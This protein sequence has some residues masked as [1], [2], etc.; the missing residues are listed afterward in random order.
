MAGNLGT[1]YVGIKTDINQLKTGL[2]GAKRHVESFS[3][4]ARNRFNAVTSAVTGLYGKIA[5]LAG[6]YGLAKL[7]TSFLDAARTSENYEVRLKVLL[8]SVEEGNRLFEEMSKY[9]G[10]VPF[11]FE[12]IMG[13]ATQLT[14]VMKGGVD[15]V[16]K[17]MPLIGDLAAA[18]GLGIEKTTEQVIRMYS[19]GAASADLFRERG[20]TAMLGFQAGVSYSAEET[21]QRLIE[22]WED[23]QSKF[24]NATGEMAKTWDGLMSMLSDKWFQFRNI[25][26][27]AGVFDELKKVLTDINDRFGKWLE[28]N[29]ELIKIKVPEYIEKI[30]NILK[31]IWTIITYDPAIMEW[32]LVGLAIGGKKWAV[33]IAGIGHMATWA[34]NLG[35][36]L[37]MVAGGILDIKDVAEA[38]FK[39]LEELVKRGENL[40]ER[41]YFRGKIPERPTKSAVTEEGIG[42]ISR[43]DVEDNLKFLNNLKQE[44]REE[45]L[46][47]IAEA[48]E[49]EEDY[50]KEANER[51][52]EIEREKWEAM[53]EM[54]REAFEADLEAR[55]YAKESALAIAIEQAEKEKAIAEYSAKAKYYAGQNW[56]KFAGQ[57]F[58][59]MQQMTDRHSKT[60]FYME[61]AMAVAEAT[62]QAF[63]A[64]NMALAN[65]PGP[66]WTI[67]LATSVLALGLANAGLIAATAIGSGGGAGGAGGGAAIG[68]GAIGTYPASVTGVPKIAEEQE[69]KG[70]LTIYIEGDILAEEY[71]IEKLAEKISN[72]VEDYDVRLVST[73]AKALRP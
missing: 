13:A 5:I 2:T 66:P 18:S 12:K 63:L 60:L 4:M 58:A 8:G 10:K 72:A 43:E 42:T 39:E 50:I 41:S 25:I 27:K 67:P 33:V 71:Y 22:A 35:K 46:E 29:R 38:N 65:P 73:E 16:T 57:I 48:M 64:Y 36:A 56:L 11:E 24:K 17:W 7:S 26:M 37:G 49:L 69:Q 52:L 6:G 53:A 54:Q 59:S 1:L 9:A 30:K 47:R 40:M 19:A 20:I 15:E 61:K 45:D 3:H 14:G 28:T 34:E 62:I 31:D 51:V 44:M 68:G 55:E 23:P 70:Q 32:G 21:R